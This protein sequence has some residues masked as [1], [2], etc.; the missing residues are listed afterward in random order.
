M[1]LEIFDGLPRQGKTYSSMYLRIL[2]HLAKGGFV[3]TN[4]EVK[5]EGIGKYI[6][7]RYGK[8]WNPDRLKILTADQCVHF[9][10]HVP[11][12]TADC[13]TLVILDEIHL[14]FNA[15]DWQK[16]DGKEVGGRETFNMATQHGKFFLDIVLISQHVSNIDGQFLKL[17]SALTRF[18]D[19]KHWKVLGIPWMR[20]CG[21]RFL[22]THY[23]STGKNKKSPPR[24]WM[25]FD[26]LV[27]DTYNTLAVL[28]GG[29]VMAGNGTVQREELPVDPEAAKTAAKLRKML[30]VAVIV[31][32]LGVIAWLSWR[33]R[34]ASPA[35]VPNAAPK[36][37]EKGKEPF[38]GPAPDA[39]AAPSKPVTFL[40]S[41]PTVEVVTTSAV[42]GPDS[43][44]KVMIEM[45]G[46]RQWIH[47]GDWCSR[48]RVAYVRR[49]NSI[50]LHEVEI[51]DESNKRHKIRVV[52]KFGIATNGTGSM[53]GGN[54]SMQGG[55]QP[56]PM[57]P[58]VAPGISLGKPASDG[59][60]TIPDS[61]WKQ[62]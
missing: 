4:I 10:R 12:G 53:Q 61:L 54:G 11:T 40:E 9:F 27:G 46:A 51:W 6:K 14:W 2:P 35:A 41:P 62:H 3:V 23:D 7:A 5:P 58:E 48:G 8:V 43:D 45:D 49:L 32:L 24:T 56:P 30:V 18:K 28:K 20:Y 57:G 29:E 47:A 22:A 26:P 37:V 21:F 50:Y 17:V 36:P 13:P 60:L 39:A 52:T 42:G 44:P 34:Q 38:T 1:A 16:S 19:L 25:R 59:P 55:S 31:G 33:G 15:R